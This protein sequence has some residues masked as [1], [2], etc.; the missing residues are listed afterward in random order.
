MKDPD[1]AMSFLAFVKERHRIWELRQENAPQP[2]TDDPVLASKKFCN[3]FRVL[4]YGSQFLVK[5]LLN[6]DVP[7]DD[8]LFR[9]WAYRY[10]NHPPAWEAFREYS[11]TGDYPVLRDWEDGHLQKFWTEYADEGNQIFSGAYMINGGSSKR[12]GTPKHIV[13]LEDTTAEFYSRMGAFFTKKSLEERVAYLSKIP[14]CSGFMA[15]QIC[16]DFGYWDPTFGENDHITLGP[17]A[18]KGCKEIDPQAKPEDT[19]WWAVEQ[20]LVDPECP[21][22]ELSE[23]K[24]R[25]LSL[26]D[27]QNCFCEFSKYRRYEQNLSAS[28]TL[29]QP[30]HA[31]VSPTLPPHWR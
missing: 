25:Q 14:F 13:F 18:V 4:D 5:E 29:F 28:P 21:A 30:T 19:F 20:L 22:L 27:I 2:W 17:G 31:T 23:G 16:T 8:I 15:M 26:M 9:C 24:E 1:A 11:D 6:P 7:A 10:T 12:P 3:V